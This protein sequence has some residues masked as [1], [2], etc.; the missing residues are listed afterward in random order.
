MIDI[1]ITEFDW[2]GW[3]EWES[4]AGLDMKQRSQVAFGIVGHLAD[5]PNTIVAQCAANWRACCRFSVTR[6]S[7]GA[8][9][10]RDMGNR[11]R[12]E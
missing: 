4:L 2:T 10:R 5:L 1:N 7:K 8:H 9:N 12:L 3:S 6:H 11:V